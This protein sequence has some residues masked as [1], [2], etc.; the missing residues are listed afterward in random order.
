MSSENF[1]YSS[2]MLRRIKDKKLLNIQL[3]TL[4]LMSNDLR[5]MPPPLR[6]FSLSRGD[7]RCRLLWKSRA[8]G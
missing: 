1:N 2:V 4:G 8:V 3:L 7:L 5:L 6:H